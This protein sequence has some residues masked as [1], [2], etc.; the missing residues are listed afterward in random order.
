MKSLLF[1]ILIGA[2]T[3][4]AP[5]HRVA[6]P[7]DFSVVEATI[8]DL[9][10]ALAS[11]RV[12]SVDLVRR[13]LARIGTYEPVLPAGI[14]ATRRSTAGRRSRPAVRAAASAPT[15]ASGR[16]TSVPRRRVRF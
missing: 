10:R 12:T 13:Y 15:P 9:Q 14:R 8:A 6:P 11:G 2:Q 4:G 16:P 5:A 7:R 3:T 1:S